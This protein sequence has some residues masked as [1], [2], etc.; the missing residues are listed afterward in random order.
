LISY[1]S[2]TTGRPK[3]VML[4]HA[5]MLFQGQN[6]AKVVDLREG[7]RSVHCL[8]L[9]HL[10]GFGASVIGNLFKVTGLLMRWFTAEAFFDGVNNLGGT[11]SSV[12]PTM[13]V[14]ML[15]HPEFDDVDWSNFRWIVVGA[16]PVPI[17]LADE[18]EKR[19]GAKVLEGYG[20][21]ET[22]P[23]ATLNRSDEPRRPGSCGRPVP[24]VDIKI[25]D[26][27]GNELL[28]GAPG[29]VCIKGP[30]VM[31]G[32]YKMSEETA[33]TIKD[34]WFLSGDVGH[35]DEDGYLYIT[36]RKKDL[37]IRG[38]FNI[39]PRDIEEVL[40]GHHAVSEAAVVGIPDAKLGEQVIAYV[41]L[42][43]SQTAS[44]EE[45]MQLCRERLAKYKTPSGV[46]FIDAL[47]KNP[48]G[49]ILK[50]DL[51]EL[52]KAERGIAEPA[53]RG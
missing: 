51:R 42:R 16:A 12:V 52:A 23:A 6:T 22:S 30:N 26:D 50:K 18:F 41:V 40:Y 15:S 3:G 39:F 24:N 47:P 7:D 36:E 53:P 28:A 44:E 25:V 4:T 48:I 8:P 34:G 27:D 14:Y 33:R 49:K 21:T 31:K 19:T 1:T 5:N 2:G 11:N 13:L 32:Y 43:P 10:F 20:L 46:R 38:G 45:L 35:L 29:E 9:A 17:E 37:I